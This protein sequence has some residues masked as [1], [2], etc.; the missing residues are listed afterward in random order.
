MICSS[1]VL[2]RQTVIFIPRFEDIVPASCDEKLDEFPCHTWQEMAIK[3]AGFL[4]DC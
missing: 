2:Y 3:N 1:C 4:L